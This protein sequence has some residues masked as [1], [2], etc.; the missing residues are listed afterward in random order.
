M[1]V[2][3]FNCVSVSHT[4]THSVTHTHTPTKTH[5][6]YSNIKC[7]ACL[8]EGAVSDGYRSTLD[9][10]CYKVIDN[11]GDSARQCCQIDYLIIIHM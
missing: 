8:V 3:S 7:K 6:S 2:L 1:W 9:C 4:Y 11:F 5:I 10:G